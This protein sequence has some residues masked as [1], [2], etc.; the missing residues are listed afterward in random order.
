MGL[1]KRPAQ[2]MVVGDQ[3]IVLLEKLGDLG[4]RRAYEMINGFALVSSSRHGKAA[5]IGMRVR[6]WGHV[7]AG[8]LHAKVPLPRVISG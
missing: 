6:Y 1:I 5:V 4:L 7:H 3:G 8:S 2:L